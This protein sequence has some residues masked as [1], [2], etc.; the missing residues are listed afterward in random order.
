MYQTN[1]KTNIVIR[2]KEGHCI[3]FKGS[4]QED[5]R[6]TINT[7]ALNIGTPQYVRQIP[8]TIKG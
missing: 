4:V 5:N 1:F 2:E 8:T 6:T 7:Y 3:M